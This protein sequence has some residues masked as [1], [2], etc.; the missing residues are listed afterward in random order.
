[1]GTRQQPVLQ[2]FYMALTTAR[3]PSKIDQAL[4]L[5]RMLPDKDDRAAFD[6]LG[7]Y[8]TNPRFS[9]PLRLRAF[10]QGVVRNSIDRLMRD[11]MTDYI[12]LIIDQPAREPRK[13][14]PYTIGLYYKIAVPQD[15]LI[16]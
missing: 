14:V 3:Q 8:I 2:Q 4:R 10:E 11:Y 9:A 15:W 1:M 16:R 12:K 5:L 6:Y 13:I 7:R